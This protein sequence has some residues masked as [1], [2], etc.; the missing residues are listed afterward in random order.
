[1]LTLKCKTKTAVKYHFTP[2]RM[3]I[4]KNVQ[5]L[6]AGEGVEKREFFYTVG[7][8]VNWYNHNGELYGVF[9]KN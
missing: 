2:I 5:I 1:M 9:L 7:G 6:S 3:P 8:H 4:I